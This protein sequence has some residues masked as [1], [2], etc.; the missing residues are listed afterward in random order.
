MSGSSSKLFLS[1]PRG[2]TECQG[3][4]VGVQRRALEFLTLEGTG[5]KGSTSGLQ[6]YQM[7]I[8][9]R[10][11]RSFDIQTCIQR[12]YLDLE[13]Q[14]PCGFPHASDGMMR[15][16]DHG[17]KKRAKSIKDIVS[18]SGDGLCNLAL[19]LTIPN[20]LRFSTVGKSV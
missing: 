8:E 15:L 16:A 12:N 4:C 3:S 5:C 6:L 10:V 11:H 14:I 2:T 17:I 19:L 13:K 18:Q 20:K 7:S 1:Q 9:R